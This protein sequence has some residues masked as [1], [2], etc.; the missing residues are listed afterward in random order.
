[1]AVLLL[2]GAL[3]LLAGVPF[4]GRGV[5]R[6]AAVVVAAIAGAGALRP[7]RRGT[8]PAR[9]A[10]WIEERHPE[11]RYALVTLAGDP[12]PLHREALEQRVSSIAW[13]RATQ[14]ALLRA[15]V[16]PGIVALGAAMLLAALP[17]TTLGRVAAPRRGDDAMRPVAADAP[18]SAIATLTVTVT[19]PAYTRL[20]R[21]TVEDPTLVTAVVG[22]RVELR[23]RG[24]ASRVAI[25]V[26]GVA[27]A[28]GGTGNWSFVLRAGV[29]PSAI[30]LRDSVAGA[31]RVVAIEPRADA[32]PR[33]TLESPARDTVLRTATGRIPL[34]AVAVD[35]FGIA[36]V[37]FEWIVS[38]G[39]GENFTF[40]SGVAAFP[41]NDVASRTI[42]ASLS[43][44]SMQLAPGSIVHLRAV[45]RDGNSVTGP[46][47]G[48][49]ETRMLRVA[50]P[51]EYDS[52]AVE[53]AAPP[54][55]DKSVLSQRMLIMQA[56]ALEKRRPR[57]DRTTLV[58]E[59]TVIARDQANLRKRVGELVFQRLTG[60]DSGE[61][62]HEDLSPE[63][64]M[65]HAAAESGM[66]GGATHGDEAPIVA[67]NQPLLEAYNAMWEAQTSLALAELREALPAM[68]RAL[69]AIQRA[70]A[71]ERLYLRGRQPAVVID[72]AKVRLVGERPAG[73]GA[74]TARPVS[75]ADRALVSR[76]ERALAVAARDGRAAADSL[77]L[78]RLSMLGT[79]AEG[80]PVLA[81][82][83]LRAAGAL[84][85]DDAGAAEAALRDARRVVGGEPR[86][87]RGLPAWGGGW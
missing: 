72:L 38:A 68:Y 79:G 28:A 87:T 52:V 24:H 83:L 66:P 18:E 45:A 3:D 47:E 17:D 57:L 51:S 54:E 63:E 8:A 21:S 60:E 58:R 50:R 82:A 85:A 27:H 86:T 20:R 59:A 65:A 48:V 41:G 76:F 46:G 74:R 40:R 49:S 67:I 53:A 77:T 9:V 13:E 39:E 37:R 61:H 62:S 42:T 19:P 26:D 16:I 44:D 36:S 70:R 7:L 12:A 34:R 35:D 6:A 75:T 25:T 15:V 55:A 2:A 81:A 43:L 56:E 5:L 69:D 4:A 30:V 78:L 71:A 33:V 73:T 32:L 23:G 11:L 29:R 64:L 1:M 10:L 14:R 84:R 22:S 80:R 31:Q